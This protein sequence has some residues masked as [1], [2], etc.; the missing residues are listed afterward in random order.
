MQ[1]TLDD[2]N[3]WEELR[4]FVDTA[5]LPLYLYQ[6]GLPL[7]EQV[8]RM[9]YLMGLAAAIEQKLKG[10]VLLFPLMYQKREERMES[11][12]PETFAFTFAIRFSGDNWW[13]E[14]EQANARIHYLTVGDEDLDSP[15][16]FEVTVD[17]C[18]QQ[19][20]K[21]WKEGARQPEES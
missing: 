12:L 21:L 19:I 1:W 17:V 5:L 6:P 16:R 2:L 13:V 20:L 15:V 7:A 3:N 4:G 8:K 14:S 18:Y 9:Q 10:R 11:Q